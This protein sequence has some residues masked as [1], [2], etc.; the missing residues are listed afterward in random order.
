MIII[1]Y[2]IYMMMMIII[3]M[4][5][6]NYSDLFCIIILTILYPQ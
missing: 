5:I 4:I 2:I 3:I 1:D 6:I